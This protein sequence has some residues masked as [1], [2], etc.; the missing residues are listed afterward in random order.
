MGLATKLT[1]FV[2]SHVWRVEMTMKNPR[3]LE[4]L[5][6][7]WKAEEGRAGFSTVHTRAQ[8][9]RQHRHCFQL[10]AGTQGGGGG[11]SRRKMFWNSWMWQ[12]QFV[13]IPAVQQQGW[14]ILQWLA[15]GCWLQLENNKIYSDTSV[16]R[17]ILQNFNNKFIADFCKSLTS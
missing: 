5:E 7:L 16:V 17:R 9:K 13:F 4:I 8:L 1:N 15:F 6:S 12:T 3:I 10:R 11:T 14:V 2:S